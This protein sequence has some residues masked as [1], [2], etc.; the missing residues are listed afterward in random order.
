MTEAMPF[1]TRIQRTE[2]MVGACLFWLL[3]G[4]YAYFWQFRGWNEGSRLML[5]YALVDHGR[6]A[7]DGL[8]QQTGDLAYR[9]GHYYSLKPPGH[10]II[11]IPLYALLRLVMP[12]HPLNGPEIKY[13][14][15]DY[16][17][18][19]AT[20][21]V[22]TAV[23][24]VLLWQT[25]RVAGASS[26]L[27]ILLC[28]SFGLG[29]S[30]FTY[31]TLFSGHPVAGCFAFA[32]V[33]LALRDVPTNRGVVV[34]GFCAGAATAT[35]YPFVCLLPALVVAI[36]FKTK[37]WK[38]GA[39]F[40]LSSGLVV[41]GLL[42]YHV[43]AFG[44]PFKTG[45]SF[46]TDPEFQKVYTPDNPI[47]LQ[48]PTW[49]R[50]INVLFSSH[51]LIWYAPLTLLTPFGLWS[52]WRERRFAELWLFFW[53]FGV[54]LTVNAAHPT[55]TGGYSTGPRYTQAALVFAY[56]PIASLLK[57]SRWAAYVVW[58]LLLPG[59]FV[60]L[61]ATACSYGGRLPDIGTPGGNNP[62]SEVILRDYQDGFVGSSFGNVLLHGSWHH[63]DRANLES[64]YPLLVFWEL[65]LAFL[66][67][68]ACRSRRGGRDGTA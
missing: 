20:S 10:A 48:F 54:F 36:A 8:E 44:G 30:A 7:I 33:I 68:L 14:W 53:T 45:Y 64:L 22:A 16:L 35:E 37:H 50:T 25:A 6:I 57:S 61:G 47:G 28:V 27:A 43:M 66:I 2:A 12:P 24:G 62:I 26:A 3:L 29:S 13:W 56:W 34:A 4:S 46:I 41:A 23:A 40:G 31:A 21:G 60:G 63:T 65:M 15:P 38:L 32:A 5:T 9:D 17:L 1:P 49:Q 52:W 58:A 11:A 59:I 51:G 18:T 67:L 55:W 42:I 19:V 39:M